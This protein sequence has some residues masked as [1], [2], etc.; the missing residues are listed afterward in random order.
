MQQRQGA[1]W[2]ARGIE[3]LPTAQHEDH[4]C[5]KLCA[6]ARG[7]GHDDAVGRKR[8]RRF[9][10]HHAATQQGSARYLQQCC[11]V[12]HAIQRKKQRWHRISSAVDVGTSESRWTR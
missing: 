10:I 8:Y 5:M 4:I 12:W 2:H 1:L 9:C 7:L 11:N 3:W 6:N